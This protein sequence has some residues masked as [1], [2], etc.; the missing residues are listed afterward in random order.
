MQ[1]CYIAAF[2]LYID[3]RRI[4]ENTHMQSIF[5][6]LTSATTAMIWGSAGGAEGNGAAGEEATAISVSR[7]KIFATASAAAAAS[8]S[9]AGEAGAAYA[10]HSSSQSNNTRRLKVL[11]R[12]A[13]R[14]GKTTLFR[15]LQGL[16]AADASAMAAARRAAAA[17][18]KGGN[19]VAAAVGDLP[20]TPTNAI[21]VMRFAWRRGNIFA[22]FNV[23]DVV[24]VGTPM[25][26]GASAYSFGPDGNEGPSSSAS[27]SGRGRGG[28]RGGGNRGGGLTAKAIVKGA[29]KNLPML[30][31]DATTIDVYN[32]GGEADL[33]IFLFDR[34]RRET[35][36]YVKKAVLDVP[37]G[38]P[39]IIGSN[40][41]DKPRGDTV[42][43]DGNA[44]AASDDDRKERRNKKKKNGGEDDGCD[45]LFE[46][47]MHY[48][49]EEGIGGVSYDEEAALLRS[50]P[51]AVSPLT[52]AAMGPALAALQRRRDEER[53]VSD[54]S[55]DDEDEDALVADSNGSALKKRGD[56]KAGKL[57]RAQR[58]ELAA[59]CPPGLSVAPL[60]LSF[61]LPCG[62]GMRPLHAALEAV[63]ALHRAKELEAQGAMCY[64]LAAAALA[65]A[66]R[67][68]E[69]QTFRRY[70]AAVR[71]LDR[72]NGTR[73]ADAIPAGAS[74]SKR[75]G[76]GDDD[77]KKSKKEKREKGRTANGH[78]GAQRR[79][80]YDDS[81]SSSSLSSLCSSSS[82]RSSSR[83]VVRGGGGG[84]YD[85][86]SSV[87][88]IDGRR[89]TKANA[90]AVN[91]AT[92]ATKTK[93]EMKKNKAG[94]DGAGD[95]FGRPPEGFRP[96]RR[97]DPSALD[98]HTNFLNAAA[99][100]SSPAGSPS[101]PH[102]PS[103]SSAPKS[104]AA[105][106][107]KGR[108]IE[109][110]LAGV[111]D[112]SEPDNDVTNG[113]AEEG[114]PS[115]LSHKP[116]QRSTNA[117]KDSEA[118]R[119][120]L[121]ER[122][123]VE[124]AAERAAAMRARN[125]LLLSKSER[126]HY[127]AEVGIGGNSKD[128]GDSSR[129]G[130]ITCPASAA[131]MAAEQSNTL[132]MVEQFR[133]QLEEAKIDDDD[134]DDDGDV[135]SDAASSAGHDAE[136]R[137]GG[138]RGNDGY[139]D[140]VGEGNDVVRSNAHRR[141]G[142]PFSYHGCASDDDGEAE[143]RAKKSKKEKKSGRGEK[144]GKKGKKEKREKKEKKEKK[145]NGTSGDKDGRTKSKKG[146]APSASNESSSSASG[147]EGR[148]QGGGGTHRNP[149]DQRYAGYGGGLGTA[150]GA[151]YHSGSKQRPHSAA[152][153]NASSSLYG[154]R[155]PSSIGHAS[156]R[157][158][159]A[160]T[161]GR[162]L[163]F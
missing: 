94:G 29:P 69:E 145:Q 20:Y 150:A 71:A 36:D 93:K 48:G 99:T 157:S 97:N 32:G 12:G 28:N 83:S 60:L 31:I 53:I 108:G 6:T 85:T 162:G 75:R 21:D 84:G 106:A 121:A 80:F 65:E 58:A 127:Y 54:V 42:G 17:G 133:R 66:A 100:T 95:E 73:H 114:A 156:G 140:V 24:D 101:R 52:L 45:R 70:A 159:A 4:K 15:K 87:S 126:A 77:K 9:P 113:G 14:T 142:D 155:G 128:R 68:E 152:A 122:R 34:T 111:S 104:S 102:Q 18:G 44:S 119:A 81:S 96:T 25:P 91:S 55:S 158:D 72:A 79:R 23:W 146:R 136:A 143:K 22:E 33:V 90:A 61:S 10:P 154:G 163:L 11:I 151:S 64:A 38:C 63:V 57:S 8:S 13:R 148:G 110:F 5:E 124:E 49:H 139:A 112:S 39:I 30:P 120:R 86:A 1:R 2:I 82:Q 107:S 132:A 56:K 129:G 149:I 109:D 137:H 144:E 116:T 89:S 50:I 7:P 37:R 123:A 115:F 118:R 134:S 105:V 131:Q 40:F 16:P 138:G 43:G 135:S 130:G 92:K 47:D 41:S 147:G 19:G 51:A 26:M 117:A 141:T 125:P 160:P 46:G 103:S 67:E 76:G 88:S 153:A 3:A 161:E 59:L 78:S 98:A 35:F 74:E 27:A 62:Y